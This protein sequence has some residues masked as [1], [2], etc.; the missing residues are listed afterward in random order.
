MN[1][2][3]TTIDDVIVYG[4]DIVTY[5]ES[6][7]NNGNVTFAG[8]EVMTKRPL[9]VV[10]SYSHRDELFRQQLD[11]A[12]KPLVREGAISIWSDHKIM[13]GSEIDREIQAQ[14]KKQ[15]RQHLRR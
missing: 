2:F 10:V 15:V 5:I 4:Y 11:V 8:F 13:A 6:Y 9:H 1:G 12:M 7:V 14:L 3:Y